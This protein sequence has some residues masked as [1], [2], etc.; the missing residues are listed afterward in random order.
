MASEKI[1]EVTDDNFSSEVL[2][3]EKPILVDFWA[4]WCGPC[5]AIAPTLEELAEEYEGKVRIGK[6]DVDGNRKVATQYQ[7]RSI[8][9]LLLFKGGKVVGHKMGAASKDALRELLDKAL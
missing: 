6:L 9:T 7:I 1:V 3:S 2:E 5:K 4:V 8:P